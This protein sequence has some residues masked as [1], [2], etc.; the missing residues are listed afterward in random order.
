M[1]SFYMWCPKP[2]L[3]LPAKGSPILRRFAHQV[4]KPVKLKTPG[5]W[6]RGLM[7]ILFEAFISYRRFP[8]GCPLTQLV[9]L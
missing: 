8:T 2:L 7:L 6:L 1:Y 9:V 4:L 5:A 3:Q